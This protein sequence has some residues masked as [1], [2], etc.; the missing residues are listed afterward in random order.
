MISVKKEKSK[1]QSEELRFPCLMVSSSSGIVILA[2]SADKE[3]GEIKGMAVMVEPG[4]TFTSL[5]E[6]SDTWR[7]RLFTEYVGCVVLANEEAYL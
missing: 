5:G 2:S 3:A 6:M 4:D 1:E 7:Y